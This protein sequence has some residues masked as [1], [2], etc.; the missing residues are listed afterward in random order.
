MLLLKEQDKSLQEQLN[1]EEIGNLP[2]KEFRVMIVMMTQDLA[3]RMEAWIEKIQDM[4]NKGLEELKNKQT[5]MSDSHWN[6]KYTRGLIA[7]E[8]RKKNT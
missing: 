2:E 3:I 4:F 5:E 1:E 8:L 7:K 6:K